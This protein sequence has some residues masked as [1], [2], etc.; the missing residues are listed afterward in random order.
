MGIKEIEER[1]ILEANNQAD[2]LKNENKSV[3]TGLINQLEEEKGH[4]AK[5]I[6]KE[7]EEKAKNS[8]ISL[9]TPYLLAFKQEILSKKKSLFDNLFEEC[10]KESENLEDSQYKDLIK[11]LIKSLE[12]EK[13]CFEIIPPQNKE[14]IT[15]KVLEELI[16]ENNTKWSKFFISK[17]VSPIKSGFIVKGNKMELNFSF[18]TLWKKIKEKH[19]QEIGKCLFEG[20]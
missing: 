17:E 8:K 7:Y 16:K 20:I 5:A 18:D 19:S 3:L 14:S 4:I 13:S 1:L 10:V 11:C 6:S 2:R 12:N 9:M 15:K